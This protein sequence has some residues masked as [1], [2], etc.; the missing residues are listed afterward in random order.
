M[1]GK[2]A[3]VGDHYIEPV[4][5]YIT[6]AMD[7]YKAPPEECYH[8]QQ[9]ESLSKLSPILLSKLKIKES[10]VPAADDSSTSPTVGSGGSTANE[11]WH[12]MEDALTALEGKGGAFKPL[13][14]CTKSEVHQK[15][16]DPS[17]E[18]TYKRLKARVTAADMKERQKR[19]AEKKEDEVIGLCK[20]FISAVDLLKGDRTQ[21]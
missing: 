7:N 1:L 14:R 19:E 5:N 16:L 6:D 3:L 11:N 21:T 20:K 17:I 15:K 4:P 2:S 8:T 13:V 9:L 18:Q 10:S 12:V